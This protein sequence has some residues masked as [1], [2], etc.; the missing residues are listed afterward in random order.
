MSDLF[1]SYGGHNYSR[2][3]TYFSTFLANLEYSYPGFLEQIKLG[4]FI[5]A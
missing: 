4:V 3:L 2:Y 1:F 5:V